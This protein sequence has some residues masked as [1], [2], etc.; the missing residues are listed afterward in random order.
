MTQTGMNRNAEALGGVLPPGAKIGKYEIREQVGAGGQS[1]I[2][3]AW[4]PLLDRHVAVNQISP[5]LASDPKFLERYRELAKQLARLDCEQ[6]VTILD[7]IEGAQGELFVIMEFV[8]GH[9]IETTL[10][11][12]PGPIETKAVLQVVWRI[13][14]GLAA[15]HRSGIVHR[16]IKPANIIIGDGLRVKIADFGVAARVGSATSMKLGTTKYMAPELFTG[17]RVDARADLYSLGMIAYEMLL[18]REKFNEVFA[19]VVRDPHSEALRWMKWHSSSDSAAPLAE[20]NPAVPP[21]MSAIVARLL[22]KDPDKRFQSAELL[23]REI[24][25]SFSPRGP[26]AASAGKKRRA[27]AAGAATEMDGDDGVELTVV[28]AAAEPLTAAIPKKPMSLRMKLAVLGV[29]AAVLLTAGAVYLSGKIKEQNDNREKANTAYGAAVRLYRDAARADTRAAKT[30]GYE[31]A[32][33]LF[34]D[35]VRDF[36]Q[37]AVAA[38]ASFM[39]KLCKAHLAVLARDWDETTKQYKSAEDYL[40]DIQRSRSDLTPWTREME[41]VLREFD[42][43]WVHQRQYESAMDKARKAIADG[44]LDAADKILLNEAGKLATAG[45]HMDEVQVIRRDIAEQQKQGEFWVQLKKGDDLARQRDIEGAKTAY[46]GAVEILEP[47]KAQQPKIAGDLK[48]MAEGKKQQLIVE[49]A[50]AQALKKALDAEKQGN[51]LDA[52]AAYEEAIKI[53]P[54]DPDKLAKRVENNRFDYWMAQANEHLAAGRINQAEEALKNA[55]QIKKGSPA[56]AD[57]QQKVQKL[58]DYQKLASEGDRFLGQ[59]KYAEALERYGMAG[60]MSPPDAELRGK[61][62]DCQFYIQLATAKSLRIAGDYDAAIKA[63]LEARKLKPTALEVQAEIDLIKTEVAYKTAMSQADALRKQGKWPE[64][65]QKV[66]DAKKV[67]ATPEADMLF[68]QIRYEECLERGKASMSLQ[69]YGG[70]V[71]HFNMAKTFMVT[72]ELNDLI[73]KAQELRDAKEKEATP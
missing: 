3:K 12:Q 21:A 30:Q 47:L 55:G 44:Q 41:N 50:Y 6:V 34:H 56:V 51:K 42:E 22:A 16:D 32:Y 70:A 37:Q 28:P 31:A 68:K 8:E 5:A 53:K 62:I 14:A 61:M 40:K 57:Q 4:D 18:G 25:A 72:P 49:T 15:I 71:G 48:A 52:A 54:S 63:F 11:T 27:A 9:T 46:D 13:A 33:K 19:D 65:L 2:Y 39:G 24:K 35:T 29:T 36:N 67:R 23:G 38:Q 26:R 64:A 7:L 58:M 66:L 17:A 1:I 45:E 73:K 10:A 20:I 60:K 69:D 59:R 43:Y